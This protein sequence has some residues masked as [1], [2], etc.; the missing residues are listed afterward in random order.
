MY[1]MVFKLPDHR[2]SVYFSMSLWDLAYLLDKNPPINM[3]V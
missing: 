3:E 1:R 2:H